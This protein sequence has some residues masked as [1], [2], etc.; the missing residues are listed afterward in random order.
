MYACTA[1]QGGS[2]HVRYFVQILY[3]YFNKA[4][5]KLISNVMY[6]NFPVFLL[7]G[8][9]FDIL[10]DCGNFT[11]SE[12]LSEAPRTPADILMNKL[13]RYCGVTET[14]QRHAGRV[15]PNQT[16]AGNMLKETTSC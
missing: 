2:N 10:F 8:P 1:V 5:H 14:I 16:G 11:I 15:D 13:H 7:I 12:Y 3:K 6:S 4:L 9:T